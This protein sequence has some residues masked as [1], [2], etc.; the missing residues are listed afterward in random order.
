MKAS[1]PCRFCGIVKGHYAH[2]AIDMPY[3]DNDEFIAVASIGA[4][5]EGWS[6]IIPKLHKL[7]MKSF[8]GSNALKGILTS[9]VPRIHNTYGSMIAFEH[10]SNHQGSITSCGT[11]HA[12]LHL[13]PWKQS[14]I[15]SLKGS[16]LEWSLVRASEIERQVSNKEYLF[17][18]EILGQNNLSDPIGYLHIL[19]KPIS[20]FFRHLIADHCGRADESNY[21]EFPLLDVAKY[22]RERLL[23]TP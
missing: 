18:T 14:L 3:A 17:Y 6:L 8:Y 15:E 11:D 16:D 19:D 2:A 13:V 7:S 9:V 5:V 21:K 1:K 20:Q 4:L 22:T 12:H 10:G 23:T